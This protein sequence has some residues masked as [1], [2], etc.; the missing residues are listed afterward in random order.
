MNE[1]FGADSSSRC[2]IVF[3]KAPREG[4]V[5]TR[6]IPTLGA[7]EAAQLYESLLRRTVEVAKGVRGVNKVFYVSA[8]SDWE[9]FEQFSDW[10]IDT[11]R[12]DEVGYRMQNAL[13]KEL[14]AYRDVLLVGADLADVSTGDL[15]LA[16]K[17]LDSGFDAVIGPS[18]DGGYWSIGFREQNLSLFD[19]IEWSSPRV[20]SQTRSKFR[21]MD[22]AYFCL[23]VRHDIDAPQDLKYV[24]E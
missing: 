15:V 2:L 12:G 13:A 1:S 17:A 18:H 21:G 23:P 11:Q 6:L 7:E 4:S 22:A 16:Y 20:F 19:S 14:E 3:A 8:S 5:K 24:S 10:R 9:Y